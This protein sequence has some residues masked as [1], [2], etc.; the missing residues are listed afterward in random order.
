AADGREALAK[1]REARPELVISDVLM[2]L[3]DG[4]E[5]ARRLK[6]D[7]ATASAALMFYTAYF[8]GQDALALAHAHG[9][10]R[11]LLKPSDNATILRQ[12]ETVLASRRET[13]AQ[14]APD[15]DQG[16]LRVVVD[17]LLEKTGALEAQQRRIERLNRT[18]A[19]LSA[20]NALIVRAGER[21]ALLE[22][23]CR[24]AVEKGGFRLAAIGLVDAASQAIRQVAATGEGSAEREFAR[25]RLGTRSLIWNDNSGSFV[26]LPL[27]A[28]GES[29]GLLLLYANQRDFFDEEEMRL[30]HEL[31]GDIAF[32]LRHL[33]QKARMDYLAYH[34]SLTDLPNRSLFTDRMTQALSAARREKRFAAAIFV[35]VERFRMLNASFG[36]KRGDDLLREV[37]ARLRRAAR[38]QDTVARV[39]ADHFAI[40]VA[41]FDRPKDT[42]YAFL[43]R[44]DEALA[45]P[46][47]I[48]GAEL[49]V[50]VKAGIAVFPTDGDST[51][52][53]YANAETALLKAKRQG[54]RYLF[55]APEMNARVA[56]SLAMENRLRRALDDG[57]LALHYQPKID[58]A[59]GEVAGLEA[60]IRWNDAELGAVPPARFVSLLEETG[61]ILAAGR[62]ALHKAVDDI[63]RWQSLGLKV[64]R[65]SVNVSAVQLRQKDFVESVLKVIAEIGG[66]SPLLDLEITESV[67]VDDIDEST[68]KLQALRRAG[69][70]VSVDDFGTGFCSLS[71]LARLPVDTLKI[72]RSFVVRMPG[73]GYPRTIV[74]M[75]VSLAH[76]LGLRVVAE[77]V[78]DT[79]QVRLLRE[80]GCDQIQGF[81]V[82]RPVPREDVDAMLGPG[83]SK[84]LQE[85]LAAA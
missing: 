16:H 35:D 3:M 22:E 74:A 36:R 4:Y 66:K 31:A 29:A 23:A 11:V 43:E 68:R 81:Y 30:L 79:E 53:L 62:W 38:E 60:L 84:S 27:L 2:P 24:I 25:L 14:I 37:G 9:V 10:S 83:A 44:L 77:G 65:T 57:T 17:Q 78:E 85:K 41:P 75:I 76:T 72:D 52:A 1:A 28:A 8:G 18:L 20:V 13:P 54:S 49:R 5:L 69:V 6:A 73:A 12:V 15:L 40:A 51:E 42:A 39:G 55:Y 48:D 67:L 59:T 50:A 61:M 21:Q 82:S 26:A 70:E 80:L 64:P 56:E 63:R 33:A 32:A 45:Q 58:V 19:V 46:I 7:P 71:Y 34:D 47:A